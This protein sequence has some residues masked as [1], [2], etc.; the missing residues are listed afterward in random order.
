MF[1]ENLCR[2][3]IDNDYL[4]I[5]IFDGMKRTVT[6]AADKHVFDSSSIDYNIGITNNMPHEM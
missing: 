1:L 4:F 3:Y 5:S 2:L 6:H